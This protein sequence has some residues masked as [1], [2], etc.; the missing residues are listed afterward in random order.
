MTFIPS[1]RQ[2]ARFVCRLETKI[3]GRGLKGHVDA[4][5]LNV[6]MGGAYLVAKGLLDLAPVSMRVTLGVETLSVDARVVRRAGPDPSDPRATFYGIE[7]ARDHS[8]Q[9][10]LRLLVDRVRQQG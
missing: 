2:H 7:F 5:L 6:G 4:T 1:R 10:R 9:G 8:T 3:S